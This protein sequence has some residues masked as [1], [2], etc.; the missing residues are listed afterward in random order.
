MSAI[1]LIL[2]GLMSPAM[3]NHVEAI[4]RAIS[5]VVAQ[6]GDIT[7]P[8]L[9][10][11]RGDEPINL[12][13]A[14][15]PFNIDVDGSRWI[16]AGEAIDLNVTL[17]VPPGT[18]SETKEIYDEIKNRIRE[19]RKSPPMTMFSKLAYLVRSSRGG[20]VDTLVIPLRLRYDFEQKKS[21]NRFYEDKPY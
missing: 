9:L 19:R 1:C 6:D 3:G 2:I 4:P 14:Y 5:F 20:E 7:Q 15:K 10:Q 16:G 8:I 18:W 12:E 21:Q 17:R 13:I 11:N